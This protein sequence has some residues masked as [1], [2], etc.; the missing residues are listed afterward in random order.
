VQR[1]YVAGDGTRGLKA[2]VAVVLIR[3][4]IGNERIAVVLILKSAHDSTRKAE[5]LG[6]ELDII[7]IPP[8]TVEEKAM[9]MNEDF[10]VNLMRAAVAYLQASAQMTA[11]REMFSKSYFS[12]GLPERYA[13]DQAVLGIASNNFQALTLE[14]LAG[15]KTGDVGFLA[16][17]EKQA[18]PSG[19]AKSS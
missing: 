16:G 15:A 7:A 10:T 18:P 12:L 11:S 1:A 5:T 8:I 6:W 19:P 13:V 4:E 2:G 9:P 3:R 14:S 17:M